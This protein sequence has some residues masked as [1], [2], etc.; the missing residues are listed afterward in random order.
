MNEI[1]RALATYL[2][3]CGSLL[4]VRECLCSI[5]TMVTDILCINEQIYFNKHILTNANIKTVQ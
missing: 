4:H 3:A 2:H 5:K 1:V